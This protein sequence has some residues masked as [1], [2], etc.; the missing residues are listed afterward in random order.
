[1]LLHLGS[2]PVLVVSSADTAREV[3]NT[4]DIA[5]ANRPKLKF[6]GRLLYN[7]RNMSFA[8]YGD[9]WRQV[10]SICVLQLL[11]NRRVRYFRT[12]IQE[13]VGLVLGK[14]QQV[15]SLGEVLNFDDIFSTLSYD[16]VCRVVLGK[17]YSGEKGGNE[18]KRLFDALVYLLGVFNVGDY[19]PWLEWINHLNG[20]EAKVKQVAKDFDDYLEGIVQ[21]EIQRQKS[22]DTCHGAD[23]ENSSKNQNFIQVMLEVQKTK[24]QGSPIDAHC[25]KAVTLDMIVGGTDTTSTLLEWAMAELLAHQDA[26]TSLQNE[27]RNIVGNRPTISEEDLAK[28][29]YMKAVIKETLR[30]HPPVPLLVPHES[31]QSVKM[32]DYDIAEG[33][34]VLVNFWAIG[35]DP[36]SWEQPDEFKPERFLATNLDFKGQNYQYIPFGSGRRS[37]PGS[38]LAIGIIEV[39]LASLISNFNFSLADG[40]Q[41][42]HMDMTEA[43]GLVVHKKEPLRLVASRCHLL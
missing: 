36:C 3:L 28:M 27:V 43:P 2:K 37:C 8:P 31:R 38:S 14:I 4:H 35:R 17:K 16:I 1:M 5:F 15:C 42:N 29:H 40:L 25:I 22:G 23:S 6:A 41:P 34:Q 33:T 21:E 7:F 32:M 9:Y 19:I 11:S 12:I 24:D 20:Y 18:F 13:E 30:L 39:V 26:M 10:K